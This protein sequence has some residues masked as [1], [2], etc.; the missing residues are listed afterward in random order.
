MR[1]AG[2]VS[3]DLPRHF[4]SWTPAAYEQPRGSIE[5]EKE[6]WRAQRKVLKGEF[7][8]LL[9]LESRSSLQE[10]RLQELLDALDA[11]DAS[12]PSFG[13]SRRKRKKRRKRRLPRSPRP[14]LRGRSR[15]RQ[16][17]WHPLNAGSPGDI[18]LHAVFPSVVNRHEMPCILAG[19]DQKRWTVAV[20]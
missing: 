16:R 9:D 11:H 6:Q 3:A 15:C 20:A 4:S 5:E 17:Q 8:A 7:L 12:K 18:F 14:L 1:S 13:S 19:T 2:Q 10:R